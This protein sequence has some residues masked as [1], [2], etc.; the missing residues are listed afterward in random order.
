M[1]SPLLQPGVSGACGQKARLPR[2]KPR[3][4]PGVGGCPGDPRRD[5]GQRPAAPED[6]GL[7]GGQERGVHLL[8]DQPSTSC[9]VRSG[10]P[11]LLRLR[12]GGGNFC[13]AFVLCKGPAGFCTAVDLN[14]LREAAGP[15]CPPSWGLIIIPGLEVTQPCGRPVLGGRT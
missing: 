7:L 13:V 8:S 4:G 15:Q 3:A 6:M 5:P 14:M 9:L 10:R 11:F 2:N 12:A 1:G